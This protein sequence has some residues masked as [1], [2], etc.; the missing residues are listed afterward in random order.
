M[1]FDKQNMHNNQY[2]SFVIIVPA[3]YLL[4]YMPWKLQNA[5]LI[6]AFFHIFLILT[7]EFVIWGLDIPDLVGQCVT[8]QKSS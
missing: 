6:S 3:A 2:S 4:I 7:S 5:A 8:L 1:S